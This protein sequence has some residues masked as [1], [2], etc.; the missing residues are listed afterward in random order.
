M[1]QG[2]NMTSVKSINIKMTS[3]QAGGR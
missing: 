2:L 3:D 1:S